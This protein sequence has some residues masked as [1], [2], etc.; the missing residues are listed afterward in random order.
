MR[1]PSSCTCVRTARDAAGADTE[2]ILRPHVW[3]SARTA[4]T[5]PS[6]ATPNAG[7]GNGRGNLV[8]A[9]HEIV[10]TAASRRRPA[11]IPQPLRRP[12][13]A[14][15]LSPDFYAWIFPHGE[16]GQHRHGLRA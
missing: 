16:I 11:S 10:R 6:R 3:S 8:F 1:V 12:S 9:Y 5:P 2:A 7:G 13:I 4:R 14:A 15:R